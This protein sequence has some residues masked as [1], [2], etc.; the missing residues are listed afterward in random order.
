MSA[1][2]TVLIIGG[3]SGIG[4]G[5][6]QLL[7][8]R[9]DAVIVSGRTR[10]RAQAIAR[11]IG[12]TAI[13]LEVDLTDMDSIRA[14][15]AAT[16]PID[17]LVLSAA[18][19]TYAPFRELAI[20]DARNVFESKFWGYY[21]A[22]QVFGPS[23]PDT[24]SITFFSGVAADR[25]APGTVA[26]TAVNA[27]VEGLTRSLA[28]ELAPVR[29]NAVSP[30]TTDTEGWSHLAEDAKAAAFEQHAKSLPIGR[31]GRPEDVASTVV[32]LI[33]NGFT[34]GTIHHVDGGARLV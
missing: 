30:G 19:L 29:V 20:D 5:T 15:A 23:L 4:R 8:S 9:G 31:V 28:L 3:T 33:D 7:A 11:D 6:A 22:V 17:H 2:Q 1:S 13:G 18:A 25:P 34:T 26:V 21:R 24:G 16:G 14:A 32:H 10:T 27:A 12:G